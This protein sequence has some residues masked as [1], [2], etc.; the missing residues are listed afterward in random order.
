M[1]V[2]WDVELGRE[3]AIKVISTKNTEALSEA[4]AL[5][6]L[7]HPNIVRV[8]DV[9]YDENVV[10]IFMEY[11]E[12]A[13]D[14][15]VEAIA[16]MDVEAFFPFFL[17]ILYAVK[18]IHRKGLLHLDL[19]PENILLDQRQDVK[20]TDFGISVFREA[21][22]LAG[23][24]VLKKGS[25]FCLSPEQLLQKNVSEATDV[26]A[27][28]IFLHV[29][30]YKC[31]PFLVPGDAGKSQENILRNH[32][33]ELILKK[34]CILCFE[35][36]SLVKNM[37]ST[38]SKK[39]PS[40][41]DVISIIQAQVSPVNSADVPTVT[42]DVPRFSAR[43]TW[44]LAS[45]GLVFLVGLLGFGYHQFIQTTKTTLVVP[46]VQ[47]DNA[48]NKTDIKFQDVN[49]LV[50]TIIEDELQSAVIRDPFRRLVSKKE[51][52]GTRNW[53]LEVEQ[54][55][56]DEIL[57]SEV[58]C[59]KEFCTV[60]LSIFSRERNE[61]AFFTTKRIPHAD[62]GVLSQ[63]VEKMLEK[64][65]GFAIKKK[66]F[67]SAFGVV[68]NQDLRRYHAYKKNLLT[69]EY[70]DIDLEG[71][72]N[73]ARDNPGFLGAH[74]LLG[75]V[76]ILLYQKTNDGNWLSK[77]KELISNAKE[78]F[79][80]HSAVLNLEFRTHIL[81]KKIAEAGIVFEKIKN[82]ASIDLN[83]LFLSEAMLAFS[84]NSK[85]GYKKLL[86]IKDPRLTFSYF[87]HKAYMEDNLNY[88]ENLEPT[89]RR[90]S[91]LFPDNHLPDF[92]LAKSY[93]LLG[94]L[95]EALS[96]YQKSYE[97]NE[98]YRSLSNGAICE[99]LLGRY[100]DSVR[101][102]KKALNLSPSPLVMINLAEALKAEKNP[103]SEY[104]FL[105]ALDGLRTME[106][107]G[108]IDYAYQALV[109]AHLG[110]RDAATIALQLAARSE[111]EDE[112]FFL[113]AAYVFSLLDQ[114]KT[115]LY[116]AREAEKRGF[117]AHWFQLPWTQWVYQQLKSEMSSLQE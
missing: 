16:D 52:R 39:R 92:Y 12:V 44:L 75:S 7:N 89:A 113:I 9:A 112:A 114:P 33:S 78:Q 96:L 41:D 104:Y 60:N 106:N 49:F 54:V 67:E 76:Y 45:M 103:Q 43:R 26:F 110:E 53:Q 93:L 8:F 84:E 105:E 59:G 80:G 48:D 36:Q 102:F 47:I 68:S 58:S 20:V 5:A 63:V 21:H 32:Q 23:H 116:N 87:H 11:V 81:E 38:S 117:K 22:D 34:R 94:K 107:P 51:W 6:K 74:I 98:D 95:E 27:L 15:C 57:I 46:T 100:Q 3:L 50:A 37:L 86:A 56:V 69:Y 99:L 4:Q 71:I 1:F 115:A 25:W 66:D 62:L 91:I 10:V 101:N 70:E 29:F 42:V 97:N 83:Q 79:P 82:T 30:L 28:G 2:A 77:N 13:Q 40:V 19:K 65:L 88:H 35:C 61:S 18:E 108:S 109:Y 72:Q 85:E 111:Q 90:W 24:R 64:N 31:H 17:K 73:L 55:D 14:L